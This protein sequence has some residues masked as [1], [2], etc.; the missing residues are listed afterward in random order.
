[1]T[2]AE[3]ADLTFADVIDVALR[4]GPLIAAAGIWW[5]GF[6]MNRANK[7]RAEADQRRAEAEKNRHIESMEAE[8]ARH[9]ESMTAL[10]ELIRRTSPPSSQGGPQP[11]PA[12]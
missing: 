8:R 1:M 10:T 11:A 5:F 2:P 6:A 7:Q 12:E 3:T 9:T 4:T